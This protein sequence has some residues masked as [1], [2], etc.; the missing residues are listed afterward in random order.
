[1]TFPPRNIRYAAPS[2]GGASSSGKIRPTHRRV[3][4]NGLTLLVFENHDVSVATADVWIATGSADETPEVGGISHFLEHM[5]FKGTENF[6]LG[7]IEREIECVGG[8]CNAG[9]SYDFTHY[10]V[11]L[12]AESVARGSE[13]LAEMVCSSTLD[14]G[15][16]EKERLVILE[17]Y[18]RKQDNPEA[19]LFEDLYEQLYEGGPYHRSVIGT[20]ETIRSIDREQMLDYYSRHY[21]PQNAT[22]LLSG[23]VSVEQAEELA[24]RHFGGFDRSYDPLLAEGPEPTKIAH[25]KSFH[26]EKATGGEVYYSL[27]CGAPGVEEIDKIVPLDVAQ[28]ILGQGRGSILF[29]EIKEKRQLA[30][31][32]GCYYSTQKHA[33]AFMIDATCEPQKQASLRAAL[34]EQIDRFLNE[35]LDPNQLQ[36]AR[37]LLASGHLF[38]F[39]TTGAASSQ[40][41]YYYTLTGGIEF[42]DGYLDRLEAVTAEQVKEAF[43][44]VTSRYDWIEVSV[45]PGAS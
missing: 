6:G 38:S 19:M 7:Q 23:D 21:A 35:P 44:D 26:H 5:L 1:M 40:I 36:R 37:R 4:E 27:T 24:E 16:L 39:E 45:G 41:G 31:T 22:F 13:M 42:L 32:I 8:A 34:D 10:Y 25:A 43:A 17:E 28:Y 11:T 9:T 18:R 2:N 14:G 29:Q 33:S 30:S 3:L 20:E 15:E 12:P